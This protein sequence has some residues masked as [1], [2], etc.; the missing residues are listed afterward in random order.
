[1]WR[2]GADSR[3]SGFRVPSSQREA[4]THHAFGR[5]NATGYRDRRTRNSELGTPM[6]TLTTARLEL[7]PFSADAID[8]LLERDEPALRQLTGATF[9]VPLRPPPLLEDVLPLV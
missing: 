7:M 2:T 9:P 6:L 1:M 4:L 3:S 8:A 5:N